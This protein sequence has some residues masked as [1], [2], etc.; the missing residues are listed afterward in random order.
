MVKKI[1]KEILIASLALFIIT[2]IISYIRKPD[3]ERTTTL[4]SHLKS[5]NNKIIDTKSFNGEP[6][7]LHF[8]ATWC[9]TCKFELSNIDI[10]SKDYRVVSIAV[11]S[12]SDEVI[13]EFMKRRGMSFDVV[14]DKE[15]I[16]SN[17]FKVE[18][19]PTTFIFNSKG[20]IIF[21]EVGYSSTAGLIARLKWAGR[22]E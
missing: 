7:M 18:G 22:D 6:Y 8:W 19:L 11:D 3:L 2:N 10:I 13:R 1:A 9:P 17:R 4:P 14:N 16:L 20:E 12:G 21:S 5:I 15:S